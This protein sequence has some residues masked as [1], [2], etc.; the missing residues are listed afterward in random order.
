MVIVGVY[1]YVNGVAKRLELFKDETISITSSIQ[2]VNDIGKVFTDFSQ[3]FTVPASTHNNSIFQ[4]WY[5]NAIDNGFDSRVRVDAYIELDTI[6]FRKGKIQIEKAQYK[7]GVIDNYQITF[8]GS[9]IS[10]KDRFA[11]KQLKDIDFSGY[12]FTYNVIS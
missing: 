1:I 3:S 2:D 10:L 12:N 11:G 4:H 9:L 6:P 8:L 5:E 7:N